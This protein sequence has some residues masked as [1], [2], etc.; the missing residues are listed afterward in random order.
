MLSV[1]NIKWRHLAQTSVL[2]WKILWTNQNHAVVVVFRV[3]DHEHGQQC[4]VR[5]QQPAMC[6]AP[7]TGPVLC[8]MSTSHWFIDGLYSCTVSTDWAPIHPPQIAALCTV[9][10][11]S[12]SLTTFTTRVRLYI[13]T[14]KGDTFCKWPPSADID[15]IIISAP[16][17]CWDISSVFLYR[18]HNPTTLQK[19]MHLN[20][21]WVMNQLLAF[22]WLMNDLRLIW[23]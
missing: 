21:K 11:T 6:D 8:P 16:Y 3:F 17:F 23:I 4:N 20:Q 2:I 12:I 9:S 14:S 7:S 13:F 22:I 19:N 18:R 1:P 10:T 15:R 5:T